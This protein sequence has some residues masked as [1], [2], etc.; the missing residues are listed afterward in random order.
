MFD[1]GKQVVCVKTFTGE[2]LER[3][4]IRVSLRLPKEN[5]IF[6][7]RDIHDYGIFG[8]GFLFEEFVSPSDP[9]FN[10]EYSYLSNHFRL[11]RKTDI[12]LFEDIL[13]E[14]KQEDLV[15]V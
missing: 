14:V 11:I 10:K 3:R 13:N 15:D 5:E 7:I 9:I 8:L 6:T 12:S 1:I 4:G 2:E